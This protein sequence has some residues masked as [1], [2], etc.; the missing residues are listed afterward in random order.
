MIGLGLG[1]LAFAPGAPNGSLPA[2]PALL[3][4]PAISGSGFVGSVLTGLAGT[5]RAAAGAA[6]AWSWQ[7]GGIDIPG[8]AGSGRTVSPYTVAAAD[9]PGTLGLRVAVTDAG[10]TTTAV[11]AGIA[12]VFPAP[13]ALAGT[14]HEAV[15]TGEAMTPYA[16]FRGFSGSTL[17][18][19]LAPGS[20]A[21]PPGLALSAAGVLSGTPA[22]PGTAALLIRA[23]NPGG[24]ATKALDLTVQAPAFVADYAAQSYTADG[25]APTTFAAMH[26]FGR[27]GTATRLDP[28]GQIETVAADQPRFDHAPGGVPRG[29]LVEPAATNL[30]LWS[31][32]FVTGWST[33]GATSIPAGLAVRGRWAGRRIGSGTKFTDRLYRAI[34]VVSGVPVAVT[35]WHIWG[36]SGRIRIQFHGQAGNLDTVLRGGPGTLAISQADAGPLSGV[37]E[38][39]EADGVTV[40]TMSFV[41]GFAGEL[42]IGFGPDSQTAGADVV[43]LA[44]QTAA[45]SLIPAAAVA[46]TRPAE[47]VTLIGIA[48]AD[49]DVTA[50]RADGSLLTRSGVPAAGPFWPVAGLNPV[51]RLA[52]F[53][54]ASP[55]L[56]LGSGAPLALETGN[57]LS[58]ETR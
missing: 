55:P 25:I 14:W 22:A 24:G 19:A 3:S 29:L 57:A 51:K 46:A 13:A 41:P 44:V 7:R 37:T 52:G 6:Y 40:L 26:A 12:A 38:T 9:F 58:L 54:A 39:P 17:A 53:P 11:S 5:W 32:E 27:P 21:L 31:E 10:G 42:R 35:V 33:T 36:T 43:L 20:A 48:A 50:T 1:L 47:T 49:Y 4:A 16:A 34:T 30:L 23:S 8:A 28:A 2:P 18:F 15:R 56:A 45:G